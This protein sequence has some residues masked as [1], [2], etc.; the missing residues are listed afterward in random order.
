MTKKILMQNLAFFVIYIV[1]CSFIASGVDSSPHSPLKHITIA[2]KNTNF[3]R[4]KLILSFFN[5][6]KNIDAY[7]CDPFVSPIKF[8]VNRKTNF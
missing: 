1:H 7:F 6:S 8:L 5:S 3:I 4:F 2:C